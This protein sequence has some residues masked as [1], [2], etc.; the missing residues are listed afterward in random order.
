MQDHPADATDILATA[1]PSLGRR[2]IGLVALVGLGLMLLQ[3]AVTQPL[4]TGWQIALILVGL[5]FIAVAEVMRRATGSGIE[6]TAEV[7]R[8][9]DGTV[10]LRLDDIERIDQGYFAMKPSNGFLLK[11]RQRQPRGWRLGLWWR[12]GRRVGVGGMT[13]ARETKLIAEIITARLI[14]RQAA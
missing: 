2:V 10:I 12:L 9:A 1:K 8:D 14:E 3:A 7:L 13:P 11:A 4:D 5:A 6:L